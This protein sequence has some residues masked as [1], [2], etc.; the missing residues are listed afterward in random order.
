LDKFPL[1]FNETNWPVFAAKANK[2]LEAQWWVNPILNPECG[3]VEPAPK[4]VGMV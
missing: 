2:I 3:K 1:N 4:Y